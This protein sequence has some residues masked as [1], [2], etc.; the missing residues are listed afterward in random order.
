MS[1]I[2]YPTV[3]LFLYD[4]RDALGQNQDQ[5]T[6][7]RETFQRKLPESLH[8][9]I[10]QF[11]TGF[12]SEYVEL[13][14][15]TPPRK[16]PI[17]AFKDSS[18]RIP[19]AGYYYPVRLGDTYGLLLDCSVEN[20]THPYPVSCIAKLKSKIEQK[21]NSQVAI[22]GQTWMISGEL[23]T[24]SDAKAQPETIAQ[25][26]Y[27]ALIPNA[28][29]SENFQGKGYL[30]GASIFELWRDSIEDN[31]H[32]IIVIYPNKI[33]A[34]KAA[35]FI[36]DW[37]RFFSYRHRIL[38]AYRQSRYLKQQLKAKF[39]VIKSYSKDLKKE[40]F[41]RLEKTVINAQKLLSEYTIKFNDFGYQ[42]QTIE[43][44]LL[45]YERRVSKIEAEARQEANN[46][47]LSDGLFSWLKILLD[48]SRVADNNQLPLVPE[49][50]NLQ[51]PSNL[52]FFNNFRD[53]V[54]NK[55]LLQIQKD[56]ENL[57]PGLQLLGDLI[58]SIRTITEINQAEGERIFQY[59]VG[60]VGVGLATASLVTSLEKLGE[61][62]DDPIRSFLE[63][64]VQKPKP[65]WF[66]PAIPLIYGVSWGVSAAVLLM[67]V[68]LVI[69]FLKW[70]INLRKRSP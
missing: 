31:H 29:W 8:S 43:I 19:L 14:P 50:A 39:I 16:E 24:N 15:R 28:K 70:L 18:P 23:P 13:L 6:K 51:Y 69:N 63:Q 20:Q 48:S 37:M 1:D 22:L 11:D 44:N 34:E 68:L 53:D 55:Y 67:L 62:A 65:W 47:I 64:S 2:I 57:N 3:N 40:N 27:Q 49:A 42:I 59:W 56:Y 4:L 7:N 41:K 61:A 12:E 26:C 52:K 33:I 58:N 38:S 17:Y 9:S 35:E 32:V 30:L 60:I 45:N 36:P 66:D 46:Q 21:V 25:E 5:I 54:K 10:V